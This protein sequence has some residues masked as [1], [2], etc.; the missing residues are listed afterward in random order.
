MSEGE[1]EEEMEKEQLQ[2]RVQAKEEYVGGGDIPTDL[3]EI[4]PTGQKHRR[5]KKAEEK[6]RKKSTKAKEENR[7]LTNVSN[8][9]E[10]QIN[11]LTKIRSISQPLLKH[12]KIAGSQSRMLKEINASV[13]QLQRQVAQIQKAVER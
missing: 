4:V 8:Q 1:I 2:E 3:E 7:N 10:K 6:K 5:S 11:Q 9:L 12:L 13:K